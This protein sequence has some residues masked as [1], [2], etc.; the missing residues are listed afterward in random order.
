MISARV[1]VQPA[2]NISADAAK[3]ALNCLAKQK[4]S[5][6]PARRSDVIL[7]PE[8]RSLGRLPADQFVPALMKRLNLACH[9]DLLSAAQY[10]GAAHRRPQ[11]SRVFHEKNRRPIY[12]CLARVSFTARKRITEAP[13]QGFDAPG[14]TLLVS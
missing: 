2:L 10:H 1:R 12:C 9:A 13:V 6:S 5:A 8:Y 7:P 3:H 11:E 4:L 14:S